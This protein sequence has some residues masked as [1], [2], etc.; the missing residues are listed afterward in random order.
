MIK[1]AL[2]WLTIIVGITLLT[3]LAI[4]SVIV[5]QEELMEC[6]IFLW[7]RFSKDYEADKAL[8]RPYFDEQFY[9]KNYGEKIKKSKLTP[10]DYFLQRG[11]YDR[12]WRNH[13]DPNSWFNTTLYQERLWGKKPV[14]WQALS[15]PFVDFLKQPKVVPHEKTID[16]YAKQD[17]LGRAW[18]A[19]EGLLRLNAFNLSLHLPEACNTPQMQVRF[20]PQINRGLKVIYDNTQEKSFYQSDF[21]KNPDAYHLTHLTP[22]PQ[23]D[24]GASVSY[25][26]NGFSYL[27]H[28][29]YNYTEWFQNGT[30]INPTL[31]NI[32]HYCDEPLV[33]IR[34]N[35]SIVQFRKFLRDFLHGTWKYPV[36]SPQDFKDY[37]V[38]IG[39]GFDLC[40]LNT[41]LPLPNVRVIPG[42]LYT[43]DMDESELDKIK[44]FTVSYLLSLGGKNFSDYRDRD[45]FAYYIRKQVWE[46]EQNI[47][48]PTKFY[49]SYRDKK[50]FPKHMQHRVLPTPSKKWVLNS[51]FTI[52]IENSI[53]ED[54]L[55][56]KLLGC[57]AVLTVPIYI[58]C[59][60]VTD[61]FD[62]R[63]M[64]IVHSVDELIKAVNALTPN[65]YQKMLPYLKENRKRTFQMLHLEQKV[66]KD[67]GRKLQ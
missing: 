17:E 51:Q 44:T 53:E 50:R 64:I 10:L 32:S 58:G 4:G 18:L 49:I 63:G 22:Q 42:Y 35:N 11:W 3:A 29:F 45:G 31:I 8:V 16:V 14:L 60:N 57:F 54:Y 2:R 61:F 34:F 24:R 43:S 55:S 38:R 20:I 40:L 12:N 7:S 56:E 5:F 48:I 33:F 25:V 46:C 62:P 19:V 37:M 59:P 27:M 13:T 1:K 47:K 66:L 28:R 41:K 15:H 39:E 23:A 6:R 67:F 65:T 21:I 26:R 30:C 9:L 36:P 52:A